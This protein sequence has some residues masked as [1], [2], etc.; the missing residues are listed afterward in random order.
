MF[1]CLPRWCMLDASGF[2]EQAI[3]EENEQQF[4]IVPITK[5]P[6][7]CQCPSIDLSESFWVIGTE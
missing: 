1:A 5:Q 2:G 7:R 6:Q 4:S 3:G